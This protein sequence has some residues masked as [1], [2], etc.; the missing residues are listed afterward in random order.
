MKKNLTS[1]LHSLLSEYLEY[2]TKLRSAMEY[3]GNIQL[4][5]DFEKVNTATEGDMF[6]GKYGVGNQAFI[7]ESPF[8][9]AKAYELLLYILRSYDKEQ[10]IKIHKGTPYYFIAWTSFQLGDF[11]KSL[12]YMDAALSE[13]LRTHGRRE[14]YTTPA[15]SF[16]FLDDMPQAAG[17]LTLHTNLN[18]VV[19]DNLQ[20]FELESKN[21][22]KVLDI[23]NKFLRP[24]IFDNDSKARS[25]ITALYGFILE[26]NFYKRQ[27]FLRSSD[28]GSIEPFINHLFKGARIL[29]SL[30]KLKSDG[31]DLKNVVTKLSKLEVKTSLFR[32]GRSLSSAKDMY[33]KL[34]SQKESFQNCNFAASYIIRNTTGHS[35]I[36]SDEFKDEESYLTLYRCLINSILWSIYKLWLS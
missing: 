34:L 5:E 28:G 21:N 23:A 7:V 2:F 4:I 22:I 3:S 25:V 8:E 20:Q 30:L 19:F 33:D 11:E 32:G 29:E 1:E 31:S 35:L 13:D 15:L 18:A 27:I 12:F 14:G 26:F 16:F 6:F 10:F 17:F 36:W 24:V 9:R